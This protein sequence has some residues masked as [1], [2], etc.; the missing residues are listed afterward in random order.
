MKSQKSSAHRNG[1][2]A[3]HAL[4]AKAEAAQ[5]LADVARKHFKMLKA[6]HKAAR[7]AFKQ[8]KRAAKRASHEAEAALQASAAKQAT[9]GTRAKSA[10]R[11]ATAVQ[12]P[13]AAKRTTPL[14]PASSPTAR[15]SVA[16]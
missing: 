5:K 13:A 9:K 8:A 2:G 16:A 6:E 3:V 1:N 15:D 12:K 10:T 4:V 11:S 14:A 7:K